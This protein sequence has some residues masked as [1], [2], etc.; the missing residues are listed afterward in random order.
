MIV[1]RECDLGVLLIVIGGV[2]LVVFDACAADEFITTEV[3][4]IGVF[5]GP[6]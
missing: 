2:G 3:E 1:R 6:F 5:F 4:R